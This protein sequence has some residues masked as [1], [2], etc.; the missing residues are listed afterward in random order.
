MSNLK[1]SSVA[2]L[3][4]ACFF[5]CASGDPQGEDFALEGVAP[6]SEESPVDGHLPSAE[7]KVEQAERLGYFPT[8]DGDEA[9]IDSEDAIGTV[10]QTL[11][12]NPDDRPDWN[13][14][15]VSIFN[16]S[17]GNW[18]SWVYCNVNTYARRFRLQVEGNQGS[19]DD[20]SMNGISLWCEDHLNMGG[21]ELRVQGPFG[22]WGSDYHRCDRSDTLN[23]NFMAGGEIRFES[24]RG[25]DDDTAANDFRAS[26]EMGNVI[27][28]DNGRGHGYWR[29]AKTCPEGE[30]VCGVRARIEQ[31]QRSGD[32]TGLNGVE[33]ACCDDWLKEEWKCP[34]NWFGTNDGCD[35]G[36]G[37]PDP[38][39]GSTP[40]GECLA[41]GC[42]H[43][44][45][46]YSW[47]NYR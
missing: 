24:S 45:C 8:V 3:G 14:N 28:S 41:P 23:N 33:F 29:G 38:D 16:G 19:G 30:V 13:G 22:S 6:A 1:L 17:W 34:S 47:S 26:C 32:D 25:S 4:V 5:G 46:D 27:D 31:S 36:C 7:E 42:N 11:L 10:H 15:K 39:C 43:Q 9:S 21:H 35:C 40:G 37:A 18:T 2:L 12:T 20:T 44:S